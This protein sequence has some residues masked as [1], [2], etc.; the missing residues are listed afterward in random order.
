[1]C[2]DDYHCCT[3]WH[4]LSPEDQSHQFSAMLTLFRS[5]D[6]LAALCWTYST[7]RVIGCIIHNLYCIPAYCILNLL[8]LPLYY[9]SVDHYAKVENVLYNWLLYVVSSWSWGAG[10]IVHEH[11]DDIYTLRKGMFAK[12]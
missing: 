1:M 7:I 4:H 6:P 2:A 8:Q 3:H 11:G 5:C 10:L 9:I 12:R